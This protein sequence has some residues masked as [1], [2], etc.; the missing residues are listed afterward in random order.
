MATQRC[1]WCG[2]LYLPK[3]GAVRSYYCT[4]SHKEMAYRFYKKCRLRREQFFT[5]NGQWPMLHT[6]VMAMEHPN[7][8]SRVIGQIM[9]FVEPRGQR[10][11]IRLLRE[12]HQFARKGDDL[13]W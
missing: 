1:L 9:Q 11:V 8:A 2:E 3:S 10:E 6:L 7:T 4:R 5:D 12:L 13:K